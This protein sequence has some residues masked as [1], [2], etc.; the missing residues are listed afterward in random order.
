M[1]KLASLKV[2]F[3]SKKVPFFQTLPLPPKKFSGALGC[4]K[5]D[6]LN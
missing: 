2:P 6:A 1:L 3:H 5:E 4:T